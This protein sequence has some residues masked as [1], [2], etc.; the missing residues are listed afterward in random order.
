MGISNSQQSLYSAGTIPSKIANVKTKSLENGN[1]AIAFSAPRSSK[2]GLLDPKPNLMARSTARVYSSNIIRVL[3]TWERPIR[4]S[5]FYSTLTPVSTTKFELN[6]EVV[7]ALKGTGLRYPNFSSSEHSG[8][9]SLSATGIL[10][11]VLLPE[12]N[13][14]QTVLSGLFYIPLSTFEEKRSNVQRIEILECKG[15]IESPSFSRDGTI[16]ACIVNLNAVGIPPTQKAIAI[17]HINKSSQSAEVS[18]LYKC[19]DIATKAWDLLPG[20]PDA[21]LWA[22]DSRALYIGAQNAGRNCLFEL[23]LDPAIRQEGSTT[24]KLMPKPKQLTGNESI[25][26]AHVLST[27][28]IEPRLLISSTSLVE[29]SLYSLL[30]LADNSY[31][32]LSSASNFSAD[33]G[34]HEDQ[35]VSIVYKSSN[36]DVQAWVVR[37]SSFDR[38]KKYPLALLIHGG[39]RSAWENEWSLDWNAAVFAEQGY[40]VVMPNITGSTGFG[41]KFF[42]DILGDWGGQPYHDIVACFEHV[43]K[44]FDYVD[45]DRA[46][47]LG[48]SYGGYMMNLIAGQP[49]GKRLKAIVCHNGIFSNITILASGLIAS[50]S[51]FIGAQ[52]WED[53]RRWDE[54]SPHFYTK[55]WSTPMLIS[56]SDDDYRC[57][58]TEGLLAYNVC[59]AR[60]IESLFLRFRG[61][62]HSILRKENCLEWHRVVFGWLKKFSGAEGIKLEETTSPIVSDH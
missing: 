47:A 5:L 48:S 39:P 50:I 1:V 42:D 37:P 26:D 58:I 36:H 3:D 19:Q 8:D 29:S 28:E 57:P 40:V 14:A 11:N 33:L 60:G 6:G 51:M 34:L 54:Q 59:Q 23:K 46:V 52:L 43:E 35:V 18:A 16:A 45:T 38:S 27:E 17:L 21:L 31:R 32:H 44:C 41:V 49:L 24:M 25:T 2:D 55:N 20:P 62:D 10:L 7:N 12:Q 22:N 9:Y 4:E 56:H 15:S 61:E 13:L 30:D 53:P